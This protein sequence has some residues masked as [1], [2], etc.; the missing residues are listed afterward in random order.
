MSKEK[1]D[2]LEKKKR[3]LE[4]EL[5]RIQHVLDDSIIR[6]RKDLSTQLNPKNVVRKY[7][8]PVVG[9]TVVLG[10]LL[11][12]SKRDESE[13]KKSSGN[14]EISS[15]LLSEL[16]KLATRKAVS[17]ATGYLENV[18]NEKKDEYLSTSQNNGSPEE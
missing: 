6:V 4:E 16:K 9:A 11:G 17:F 8:L 13:S 1:I 2:E 5:E 15:T 3:E 14:G 7:P 18:I 12:H 10:F